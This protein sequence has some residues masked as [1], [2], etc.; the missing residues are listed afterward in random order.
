M[1]H[2]SSFLVL[3]AVSCGYADAG[4]KGCFL[5][6]AKNS[7]RSE[8][9]VSGTAA[10]QYYKAKDGSIREMRAYW[11]AV[12]RADEADMMEPVLK[13]TQEE[14]AA[15]KVQAEQSAAALAASK[16]EA[17]TLRQELAKLT[18]A[19]EAQAADMK[20]QV[21]AAR[22]ATTV[23]KDRA[24]K[25]ESAHKAAVDEVATLREE[26]KKSAETLEKTRRSPAEVAHRCRDLFKGSAGAG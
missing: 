11:D 24:D 13:Q 9:C 6:S 7:K 16:A 12:N 21:E 15:V 10:K 8:T 18:A 19:I 14:L 2:W 26:A 23:Q 17:E 3:L 4:D 1:K 20:K 22:A 25:A 5:F